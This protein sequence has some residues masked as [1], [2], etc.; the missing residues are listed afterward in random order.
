MLL[1]CTIELFQ[2]RLEDVVDAVGNIVWIISSKFVEIAEEDSLKSEFGAK[3][4]HS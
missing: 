1:C 2:K 4:P 3:L